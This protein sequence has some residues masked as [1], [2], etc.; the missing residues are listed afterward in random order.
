MDCAFIYI[1]SPPISRLVIQFLFPIQ[2]LSLCIVGAR[3]AGPRRVVVDRLAGR[4][5]TKTALHN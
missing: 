3:E 1:K 2:V 4:V 5:Q